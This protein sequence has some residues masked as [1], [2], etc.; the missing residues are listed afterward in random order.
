[1][2]A[3][4]KNDLNEELLEACPDLV[5]A[6]KTN[7]KLKYRAGILEK[8]GFYLEKIHLFLST[9]LCAIDLYFIHDHTA[10]FP[11]GKRIFRL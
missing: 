9:F 6:Y 3:M 7:E 8:V 1:M 4:E 10:L 2:E 11:N 5:E